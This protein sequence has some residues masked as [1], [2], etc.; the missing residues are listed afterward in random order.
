VLLLSVVPDA[1]AAEVGRLGFG[2]QITGLVAGA[3]GAWIAAERSD[4]VPLIG[5]ATIAGMSVTRAGATPEAGTLGPDG[6]AW[7]VSADRLLR[8]GAGALSRVASLPALEFSTYAIATG[9]D[10]AVWA[11]PQEAD[12]LVR[13]TAAGVVSSAP[14]GLPD[15]RP[16][17]PPDDTPIVS[18]L[19][20]GADGLVWVVDYGC[21]RLI[22]LAPGGPRI[23]RI[24]G[25]DPRVVAAD[26][27]GGLWFGALGPEYIGHVDAAGTVRRFALP[28]AGPSLAADVA[29]SPDGSAVYAFDECTL[30][31]VTSA[32]VVSVE[33][34]PIPASEV[35]FDAQGAL[36]LAA[37]TR[38]ARI[39][40]GESAATCDA[41]G[42]TVRV[43][44]PRR[45][46]VAAL[47]R[48]GIR[49]RVGARAF[50]A[51]EGFYLPGRRDAEHVR[52]GPQQRRVMSAGT[53]SYR[54]PE[55]QLRR[56]ARQ[57]AA[58]RRPLIDFLVRATDA[59]GNATPVIHTIRVTG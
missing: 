5:R 42:P 35:A 40:A 55:A 26:A 44:S 28:A 50:V 30:V 16:N 9:P 51:A 14:S 6:Q 17:R 24:D 13:V 53:H 59:D 4:G 57:L 12:R 7:F 1:G 11:M 54:M 48:D 15:C 2:S 47:R 41:S 31:R 43:R 37:E 32:G 22:R 39:A 20:R 27:S 46:S 52:R 18:E 36:W 8:T 34:P 33:R 45:M 56:F 29:G 19:V 21:G 58:G 25:L 23:V 49:Y 3:D 38:I 10:A